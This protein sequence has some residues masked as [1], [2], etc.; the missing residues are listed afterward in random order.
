VYL[1]S[2]VDTFRTEKRYVIAGSTVE[3]LV[4]MQKRTLP[5]TIYH[6][7][8]AMGGTIDIYCA[9]RYIMIIR[10]AAIAF[11]AYPRDLLRML[12]KRVFAFFHF[13]T[14]RNDGHLRYTMTSDEIINTR[15]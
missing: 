2:T 5:R 3:A 4:R 7:L 1:R 14:H 9:T 13:G 8:T 6:G 11:V 10:I 15:K 12:K